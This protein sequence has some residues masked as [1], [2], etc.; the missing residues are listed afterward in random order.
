MRL[1]HD[2]VDVVLG[3][4][5][6]TQSSKCVVL[7]VSGDLRGKDQVGYG[8]PT[9]RPPSP[10]PAGSAATAGSFRSCL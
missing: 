6:G 10:T 2:R 5:V 4:D 3:I 1:T 9:P 7:D 8:Y